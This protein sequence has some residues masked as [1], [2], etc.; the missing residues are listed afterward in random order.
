M[1][2]SGDLA[3][4]LYEPGRAAYARFKDDARNSREALL[5]IG[6]DNLIIRDVPKVDDKIGHLVNAGAAFKEKV[7][8]IIQQAVRLGQDIALVKYLPLVVNAGCA[9]YEDLAVGKLDAALKSHSVIVGRAEVGERFQVSLVGL[10]DIRA[11]KEVNGD[12]RIAA[13]SCTAN[14]GGCNVVR[15]VGESFQGK[16]IVAG[17]HQAGVVRVNV[18]HVN[19]GPDAVCPQ[20]KPKGFDDIQV[21]AK[22]NPGLRVGV[23]PG[24]LF[25]A[26]PKAVEEVSLFFRRSPHQRGNTAAIQRGLLNYGYGRRAGLRLQPLVQLAP[27]CGNL[28]LGIAQEKTDECWA[29][30]FCRLKAEELSQAG[31]YGS[32]GI[33]KSVS[34]SGTYYAEIYHV[35]KV[36]NLC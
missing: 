31:E 26:Q 3:F 27:E 10:N 35:A 34:G 25:L 15:F 29:A 33:G 19:P 24:G 18:T 1:H 32:K 14:S 36:K 6:I 17:L 23:L 20:F 9:A 21:S 5:H 13:F 28:V 8:N 16:D 4:H 22:K 7:R 11:G 2:W 12:N 30:A